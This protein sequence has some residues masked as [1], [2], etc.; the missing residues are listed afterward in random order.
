[1]GKRGAECVQRVP[2]SLTPL[3]LIPSGTMILPRLFFQQFRVARQGLIHRGLASLFPGGS[4]L[5]LLI[6]RPNEGVLPSL[7]RD[8]VIAMAIDG[9]PHKD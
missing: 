9:T 4:F 2:N 3:I 6:P 5:R 1:M 7:I 8:W